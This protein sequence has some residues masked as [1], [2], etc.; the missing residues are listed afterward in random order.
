MVKISFVVAVSLNNVI[1]KDGG[2]PWRLKGDL[3]FFSKTTT[4]HPIVMGRKT[5][6][7]IGRPLPNRHSIVITSSGKLYNRDGIEYQE[8]PDVLTIVR[9]TDQAI[10]LVNNLNSDVVYIIGGETIYKETFKYANELLITTVDTVIEGGDTFFNLFPNKATPLIDC[11]NQSWV[12]MD[13]K[14]FKK[15]NDNEYDYTISTLKR[16]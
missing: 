1:G 8:K 13:K 6:D 14:S 11:N 9:S 15:D 12:I 3:A 2:I 4:G 7:S 10:E 16:E 5:F